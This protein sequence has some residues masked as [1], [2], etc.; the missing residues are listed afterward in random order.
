LNCS[1]AGRQGG[2]QAR[3][4]SLVIGPHPYLHDASD[5]P[6]L[7]ATAIFRCVA[8]LSVCRPSDGLE[9]TGVPLVL[10]RSL[11]ILPRAACTSS[12]RLLVGVGMSMSRSRAVVSSCKTSRYMSWMDWTMFST[13]FRISRGRSATIQGQAVSSVCN[14][15]GPYKS[16]QVLGDL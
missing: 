16:G 9:K 12:S 13:C 7:K 5:R 8:V 2:V 4:M 11:L 14:C 3:R 1:I 15:S 6:L 10:F